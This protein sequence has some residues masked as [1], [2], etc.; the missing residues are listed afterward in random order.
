VNFN[1]TPLTNNLD[2][3]QRNHIFDLGGHDFEE[4]VKVGLQKTTIR[5]F[6]KKPRTLEVF[7][8]HIFF[9]TNVV[10]I[11]MKRIQHVFIIWKEKRD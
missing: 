1:V 4:G 6:G 10:A 5:A 2:I 11:Y 8:Y 3:P 9:D 7:D